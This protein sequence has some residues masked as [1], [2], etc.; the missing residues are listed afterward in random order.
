METGAKF[1]KQNSQILKFEN[2]SKI[3]KKRSNLK[4]IRME[5]FTYNDFLEFENVYSS[6]HMTTIDENVFFT[7]NDYILVQSIRS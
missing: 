6:K 4:F 7:Q 3:K 2:F 1:L 5:I